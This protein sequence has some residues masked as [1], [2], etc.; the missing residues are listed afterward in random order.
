MNNKKTAL[1][2]AF[3]VSALM[4]SAQQPAPL[5]LDSCYTLARQHY[6][7]L[8]QQPLLQQNLSLAL[9]NLS[10]SLW[11][12]VNFTGEATYQS[13]VTTIPISFPGIDIP[14]PAK[15]QY[16]LYGEVSESLT[17]W[18]K[19][20]AQKRAQSLN[21]AAQQA[22]LEVDL[23]KLKDRVN[24]VF[25]SILLDDERIEQNELS[26]KDIDAGI[27]R[28]QSAIRN[29]TDYKSSLDKLLADRLRNRQKAMELQGQRTSYER[30]L[31]LLTGLPE[32]SAAQLETPAM[33]ETPATLQRPELT[34]FQLKDE[35]LAAQAQVLNQR[36]IP[37][38]SVFFQGGV[39]RPSPLNFISDKWSTY[40]ITGLSFKWPLSSLYTLKNERQQ[41]A[42][43]RQTNTVQRETFEFN[44]QNTIAQ[45]L[46]EI[47]QLK[48]LY[49]MDEDVVNLRASV[50]QTAK[51]QLD[52]GIITVSDYLREVNAEDLARQDRALHKIQLL[53]AFYNYQNSLGN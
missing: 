10:K 14:S 30:L 36:I 53:L 32:G 34:A 3:G 51:V 20:P 19:A 13:D 50:K 17:D 47:Q 38:A 22:S 2:L 18:L 39:G 48:Q 12:R 1:C 21:T 35:A 46:G 5:R 28:V 15:D 40:Y 8:Q 11:P 45:Q 26:L 37:Q 41:L 31:C 33:S 27:E 44:T 49:A 25:F 52:N 23:F 4:L 29:G 42:I 7:L 9:D 6:P 16:K 43:E 24:Q